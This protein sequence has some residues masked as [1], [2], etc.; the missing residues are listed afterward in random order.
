MNAA[1]LPSPAIV[2]PAFRRAGPL[3]ALLDLLAQAWYPAGQAVPLHISLEAGHDPLV[4]TLAEEFP[5]PYGPKRVVRQA[6][7]LG[8][9]AH[10]LHCGDLTREYGHVLILEDDLLVAPGFYRYAQATLAA[11]AA[12]PRIAGVALYRY[13]LSEQHRLPFVPSSSPADDHYIQLP[14]SWGQAFSAA[15][16]QAF[17]VW[18]EGQDEAAIDALVPPYVRAW[19][20][21]SWKRVCTAYLR[22][23][24]RYFLYPNAALATHPGHAGTHSDAGSVMHVALDMGRREWHFAGLDAA[25]GVYD[26]WLEPHPRVLRDRCPALAGLDFSV[27]LYGQKEPSA[28]TGEWLLT[29]RPA[30][31]AP[32]HYGQALWPPVANVL[33]GVSGDGIRLA[34]HADVLPAPLDPQRWMA[35]APASVT[36]ASAALTGRAGIQFSVVVPVMAAADCAEEVLLAFLADYPQVELVLVAAVEV[37]WPRTLALDPRVRRLE[38]PSASLAACL[39][40]G[41]EAATGTWLL[42][43]LP[44]QRLRQDSLWQLSAILLQFPDVEW[45]AGLPSPDRRPDLQA[46]RL[47]LDATQ[48]AFSNPEKLFR[49]L[50][51]GQLLIRQ[52]RWRSV[53]DLVPTGDWLGALRALFSKVPLHVVQL[54]I[55]DPGT[56]VLPFQASV[57]RFP[58]PPGESGLRGW[59]AR[60]T[61]WAFVYDVRVLRQLHLALSH[62]P[63]V[64]RRG[65]GAWFRSEY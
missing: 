63:R 40:Q 51:P 23:Q 47:R 16:W 4:A 2:I 21:Q 53:M 9:R 48:A 43:L 5:W 38:A 37:A 20:A 29:T 60:L 62:Y 54:R 7:R 31:V 50:Q 64:I 58:L 19:G 42:S 59:S 39:F 10:I 18:R 8:L 30:H 14:C 45:L 25:E 15:Q 55:C 27:D 65:E 52:T 35:A 3:K 28:W 6:E 11:S 26:A 41:L 12:D 17:T 46:R 44:G 1:P 34:R 57:R 56:L 24:D 32:Q 49:S 13:A 22:A 33:A 36:A 61:R